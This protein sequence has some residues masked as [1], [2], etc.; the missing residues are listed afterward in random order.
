VLEAVLARDAEAR[1]AGVALVPGVGF[2]VVPTDCLALHVAERMPG[3]TQLEVA[4]QTDAR[5]SS[6]TA[7][8]AM[9]QQPRGGMVRRNKVLVPWALGRGVR[10]VHFLDAPRTAVPIPWGDLVTAWHSTG[11]A[12]ITVYAAIPRALGAALRLAW[13]AAALGQQAAGVA[14]R[15]KWLRERL[16]A[17]QQGSSAETRSGGRSQVWARA[18][19]PAGAA[20]AWLETQE[21]YAF[22]AAASVRAVEQVLAHAVRG[23]LTPAQ[24]FGADFVLTIPRTRRQG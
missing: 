2:D 1:A 7:R 9:A 14:L 4:F 3:A 23:A 17:R 11:I 18:S 20:E 8:S 24:A 21:A 16:A 22:T 5:M 13:P 15:S 12:D 6:G 10:T 19:G